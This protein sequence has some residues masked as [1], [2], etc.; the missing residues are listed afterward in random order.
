MFGANYSLSK[1]TWKFLNQCLIGALSYGVA[2]L[3]NLPAS[4][5]TTYVVLGIAIINAA[6]NFLKHYR[7]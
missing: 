7:D 2:Y 6:L 4:E 1:T 3:T 5:Q